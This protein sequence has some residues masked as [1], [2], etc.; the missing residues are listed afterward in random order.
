MTENFMHDIDRD[1]FVE[2]ARENVNR[3][4][5]AAVALEQMCKAKGSELI[6]DLIDS[7]SRLLA[8]NINLSYLYG[9]KLYGDAASVIDCAAVMDGLIEESLLTLVSAKREINFKSV[10]EELNIRM[11]AKAFIVVVMNLLQNALLYSPK[12]GSADI[13]LEKVGGDAVITFSNPVSSDPA[14][15]RSGFGLPL[16]E[17][18]VTRYGGLFETKTD[19]ATFTAR[20]TLPLVKNAAKTELNS[21][22]F[23]YSDYM[24]ERFKPVNL[25]LEEV[26]FQ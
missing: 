7:A 6:A 5:G 21:P 24:S 8:Q 11:D 9:D 13:A 20:I 2:Y 10:S 18:I 19:G 22:R 12:T 16:C 14:P 25:F 17:K 23:D 1:A 15:R 26:I 3:V 4:I